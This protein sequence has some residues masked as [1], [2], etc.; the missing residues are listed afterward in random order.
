MW[1]K[2]PCLLE[3]FTW[4]SSGGYVVARK[5]SS[6]LT[7][8]F[9]SNI[10][11]SS[12][13]SFHHLLSLLELHTAYCKR[14][15]QNTH[16]FE[17]TH[18]FSSREK[19]SPS[20]G[21]LGMFR[22]LHQ[23]LKPLHFLCAVLLVWPLSSRTSLAARLQSSRIPGSRTE[24]VGEGCTPSLWSSW[25]AHTLLLAPDWPECSPLP[26]LDETEMKYLIFWIDAPCPEQ[27]WEYVEEQNISFCRR[28]IL[29]FTI[30]TT[31]FQV[32]S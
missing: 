28:V 10:R 25:N 27:M 3:Q 5:P 16:G 2:V 8:L 30:L 15:A 21:S 9:L 23:A 22:L 6:V 11:G 14:E 19:G 24:E 4:A 20:A 18:V 31:M 12:Q 7:H 1:V 17:K 29:C 13:G 26:W 32:F